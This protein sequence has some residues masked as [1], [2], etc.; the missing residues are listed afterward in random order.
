MFAWRSSGLRKADLVNTFYV[1]S[2]LQ[3]PWKHSAFDIVHL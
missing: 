3:K 2:S 1:W